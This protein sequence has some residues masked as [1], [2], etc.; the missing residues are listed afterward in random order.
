[1]AKIPQ[2]RTDLEKH[3]EEQLGFL[4]RSAKAYDGGHF[5]EAKRLAAGV[6]ILVHDTEQSKSLLTQLGLK[7][8]PI[9][10][11]APKEDQTNLMPYTGL[12][13]IAMAPGGTVC[14]P[15]LDDDPPPD[16]SRF[17]SFDAWWNRIIFR[18]KKT[19]FK[20]ELSRKDLVLTVANQDGGTHVDPALDEAYARLSRQNALGWKS[21]NSKGEQIVR[22]P[23]L[24]AIRQIAHEIL[25]TFDPHY[26]AHSKMPNGSFVISSISFSG[27]YKT[28][29]GETKH[30]GQ[31][32]RVSRNDPCPCGS[33]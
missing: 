13:T 21:F 27:T 16:G 22:P 3:W 8:T 5:D 18:F 30:F 10:D 14:Y 33:G 11:S 17:A 2:T 28:T 9:F 25:K 31:I 20:I 32:P 6:R 26:E 7:S 19:D 1:M 12:V 15:A 29:G 24:A 4:L 23:E